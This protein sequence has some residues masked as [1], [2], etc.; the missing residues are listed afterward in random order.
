MRYN[1]DDI[2]K[3]LDFTSWNDKKKIDTLLEIDATLY[4]NMGLETTK[5]QR[6]ETKRGSRRIYNAIKQIDSV[7]GQELLHFMD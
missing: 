4:C 5:T 7:M 6:Q 2:Q 1:V 3:I